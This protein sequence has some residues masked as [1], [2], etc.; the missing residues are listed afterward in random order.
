MSFASAFEGEIIR[1]GDMQVE[2][3][4]SRV[5]CFELV[6]SKEAAQIEDHKIEVIGPEIDDIPVGSKISLSYTV[7]VAGKAMQ[8]DFESVMERKIHSW[9]NWG[10]EGPQPWSTSLVAMGWSLA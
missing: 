4:G 1:R 5:D 9:I 10:R 6:Q 3:D 2:V 8:P 7:E